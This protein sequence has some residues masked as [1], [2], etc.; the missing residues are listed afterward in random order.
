MSILQ[1]QDGFGVPFNYYHFAQHHSCALFLLSAPLHPHWTDSPW[2]MQPPM[3]RH[4]TADMTWLISHPVESCIH[5]H[6]IHRWP[7]GDYIRDRHYYVWLLCSA[8]NKW[9]WFLLLLRLMQH[10]VGQGFKG[11]WC[12]PRL[13]SLSW[14]PAQ[15]FE[16][17]VNPEIIDPGEICCLSPRT[18]LRLSCEFSRVHTHSIELP[19]RVIPSV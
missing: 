15:I 9:N 4:V 3:R 11:N 18:Q 14:T 10:E 8:I 19:P 16:V 12:S 1:R 5:K 6:K 2:P 7:G 17:G 13:S